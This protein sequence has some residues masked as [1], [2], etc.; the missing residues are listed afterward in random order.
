[1]KILTIV[2]ARPQFV[3]AAMVSKALKKHRNIQEKVLHTGQHYDPEMSK[4][5][6]DQLKIPRPYKNLK[7]GSG[8]QGE[9]T[10]RM[11]EGIEQECLKLKPDCLLIYGDT[12]STTAGALAASK[13]HI[14]IA[15]VEAGLR[16]FNPR[17]PEEINRIISDR[18]STTLFVPTAVAASHLKKEGI[19]KGIHRV[20][21]VMIDAIY[22]FR[23]QAQKMSKKNFQSLIPEEPYF[24]LTLHRA[25]NTND[26]SRLRAILKGLSCS[27]LPIIF[28]IHPRTSA[29][30]KKENLSLPNTV[31]PYKPV[32]YLEMILLQD[33]SQAVWTDSGGMQKEAVVL[34]KP[35]Y[36]LRDET[37]W[38]ETVESGWNQ[39]LGAKETKI[40]KALTQSLNRPPL[41][42]FPT[43]RYYGDGKAAEKIAQILKNL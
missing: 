15:H 6:F 37:E 25:E 12:N 11:L 27:P 5:F 16:S 17:M 14:P 39:L 40:K 38:V 35:C 8:P 23:T 33:Q 21:D 43:R 34:G 30:L 29:I 3:K 26:L 32:S 19:R 31:R 4:I 13:L 28:P 10:A 2:G 36:T 42:R 24:V 41:K 7:V 18:L 20:G 22:F 1:M 9:Q